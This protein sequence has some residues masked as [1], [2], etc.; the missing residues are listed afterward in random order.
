MKLDFGN[1]RVTLVVSPVD[2]RMGF[3]KLALMADVYLDIDLGRKEDVVVFVSKSRSLCKV[4]YRDEKGSVTI[5]RRLN[6]GRFAQIL[7][8]AEGQ[9]AMTLTN[10][11][12]A[13]YLDGET[14]QIRRT[15]LLVG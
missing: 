15:E 12:L 2:L 6:A 1:R 10:E 5:L 3:N 8:E 11:K 14:L 9:A 13:A 7:M 4:I